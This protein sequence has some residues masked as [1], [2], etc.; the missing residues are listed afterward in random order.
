MDHK[1][2]LNR[3]DQIDFFLKSNG[4]K[5]T[6][7]LGK[8][9]DLDSYYKYEPIESNYTLKYRGENRVLINIE[10]GIV[11]GILFVLSGKIGVSVYETI[12][13]DY[14]FKFKYEEGYFFKDE[15]RD[16]NIKNILQ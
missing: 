16:W 15:L 7:D 5:K 13:T 2:I 10:V 3:I 12:K 9:W 8:T 6:R 14:D 1:E 4:F 11:S